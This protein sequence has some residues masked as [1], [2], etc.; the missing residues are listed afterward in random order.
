MTSIG[1]RIKQ[2]RKELGLTQAELGAKLNVSDRAVSKWEQGEGDPS[3]S[4]I[5]DIAKVLDLSL[6]YLLLGEEKTPAIAIEDMDDSK[7]LSMF[8]KNDDLEN[9]VK[10][11]YIYNCFAGEYNV[12]QHLH[13]YRYNKEII[14]IANQHIWEEIIVNKAYKILNLCIDELLKINNYD[15]WITHAVSKFLDAFVISAIDLDRDDALVAIGANMFA[16]EGKSSYFNPNG[17]KTVL[18]AP[19]NYLEDGQAYVIKEETFEYFFIKAEKSPRCFK[20]ITDIRIR[21]TIIGNGPRTINNLKYIRTFQEPFL[22]QLALKYEKYNIFEK[23]LTICRD[24]LS[25]IK[26]DTYSSYLLSSSFFCKENDK[27]IEGRCFYF[28]NQIIEELLLKGAVALANE[29]NDYN[30]EVLEKM[31]T[32]SHLTWRSKEQ[33]VVWS[34]SDIDRF[35]KLHSNLPENDKSKIRCAKDKIIIVEECLKLKDLKLLREILDSNY[36]NYFEMAY[37][38]HMNSNYKPLFELLVD[39]NKADYARELYLNKKITAI[40]EML[41]VFMYMENRLDAAPLRNFEYEGSCQVAV[42]Y[43]EYICKKMYEYALE[44]KEEIYNSVKSN[45]ETIEKQKQE[46]K[47]RIKITKDLTKEYFEDLL[48]KKGLFAKKNQ[49]LFILDLCS[50]LDAIIKY[51]YKIEGEDFFARM[52][53]FFDNGPKSRTCDDGWGYQVA[54]TKYEKEVVQPWNEMRN[55]FNRLRIQRN[56]IAHSETKKVEELTEEELHKCLEFVF[57]INKEAK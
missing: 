55:L 14:K 25:Q 24:S 49:K 42:P 4:I 11:K 54:D 50:L 23:F 33:V 13:D 34:D 19:S 56:N 40:H 30:K 18:F 21:G 9:F 29:L 57:S 32:V 37:E 51:D 38:C 31:R 8:I 5:T 27:I 39:I 3:L 48:S 46:E 44:K 7:R 41:N 6:D 1:E 10:Y 22:L 2:K 52:S 20:Y 43:E 47:E 45:L 17:D 15:I 26:D 35:L 28:D 53:T 12:G 36:Y 16:I